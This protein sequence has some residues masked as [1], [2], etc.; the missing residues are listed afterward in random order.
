MKLSLATK[1]FLGFTLVL[2]MFGTVSIYGVTQ[3]NAVRGQLGLVNHGLL[4]L[5]RVVARMEI[6]QESIRRNTDSIL[7][8]DNLQRQRSI[9]SS[10]R[11]SFE[12]KIL[13]HLQHAQ[14]IIHRLE[15]IDISNEDRTILGDTYGRLEKLRALSVQFDDSLL[16]VTTSIDIE[17]GIPADE[18]RVNHHRRIAKNLTNKLQALKRSLK[19][20]ITTKMLAMEQENNSAIGVILWLSIIAV[21]IG[22][23]VTTLSLRAL[24]PIRRLAEG[25]RRISRGDFSGRVDVS[26]GDEFGFLAQ[27]FNHMV[28]S[29]S[30]W[31]GEQARHQQKMAAVNRKLK[32]TGI[33]LEL[34]R[35]Y[36]ENI[37]Q[38][39]PA[40]ILV[41]DPHGEITTINPTA[42]SLWQLDPEATVG[43][44]LSELSIAPALAQLTASWEKVL[45]N[46]E[47]MLF[48]SVEFSWSPGPESSYTRT[49]LVDLY[50]SPLMNAEGNVQGV[51][52]VG[53]DV[54]EK[55]RTKQALIQ[56]ERLATIGRMSAMVAHEI[57]NP[58]SSI[59]LNAELLEE[60]IRSVPEQDST[61]PLAL[62]QAISREVERLTEVT[63]EYLKFAR[64]PKPHLLPSDIN[65][66]LAN[67]LRFVQ[68]ELD[69]A[70]IELK[71]QLAPDL[72]SVS[73][74]QDQLR[75]AFLNLLR[76][77]SE[78][79]PT[80]GVLTV[81]TESVPGRIRVRFS[82]TGAG[83]DNACIERIFDPFFSTREGGTG[84]GL[85]L[86]QQII[87]EHGGSIACA[88]EPDQ[89]TSFVV[90]IPLTDEQDD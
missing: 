26:T 60:E 54:S 29:L 27:E 84:L 55:V 89:G 79:M 16:E 23:L 3:L 83:I 75:Q 70:G 11:Q 82:D 9:L 12:R 35:L 14:S 24:R 90:E 76:N 46:R 58:L 19:T 5:D 68:A 7:G 41:A 72:P 30:R 73:A 47:Q 67:L 65:D 37:I 4:Q 51:L 81:A 8:F 44:K 69:G 50:V 10:S 48:E 59:G 88:S 17:M 71:E 34:M 61:E 20:I 42:Q 63:E 80:G 43:S 87:S 33:D 52:L 25:A 64:L 31:E 86:T 18:S 6:L 38:S 15:S 40:G 32:Q 78:S 74:D 77:S 85:S 56:S 1:I 57:R 28:A 66:I 21:L 45:R 22:L 13:G 36:N 49:V 2:T 53:E 39:I 62:L